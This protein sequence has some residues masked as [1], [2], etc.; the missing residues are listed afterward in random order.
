MPLTESELLKALE[1]QLINWT[2]VREKYI[3]NRLKAAKDDLKLATGIHDVWMWA[4]RKH[5][6]LLVVEK[7]FYCPAFVTGKGETIFSNGNKANKMI[8]KDAVNDII[9]KVLENGG[10]VEF[11]DDL[12][13]YNRIALVEQPG[14]D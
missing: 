10:D 1:P 11:V 9:E 8:T 12:K 2:L 3:V 14:N 5:R 6:Q 4:Y 13:E 7:D